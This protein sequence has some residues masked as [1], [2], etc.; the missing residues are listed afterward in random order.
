MSLELA[1]LSSLRLPPNVTIGWHECCTHLDSL[2]RKK[3]LPQQF[4]E[5]M[6]SLVPTGQCTH[7][8]VRTALRFSSTYRTQATQ[9]LQHNL[10]GIYQSML[11]FMTWIH[12]KRKPPHFTPA[13]PTPNACF[14]DSPPPL[15]LQLMWTSSLYWTTRM[16]SMM[17]TGNM[18]LR[19]PSL[20]IS[21]PTTILCR[22]Y[23]IASNNY[24]DR[25]LF[26]G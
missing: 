12:T 2:F 24:H 16:Y 7:P 9:F 15:T 1:H 6:Q 14:N 10:V 3:I 18:T 26:H 17:S 20:I 23:A 25:L 19:H 22:Q 4:G 8:L 5:V 13:S 21:E 11:S